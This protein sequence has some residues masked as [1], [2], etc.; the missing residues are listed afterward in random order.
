MKTSCINHPSQE[1]LIIK[2]RWQIQACDGDGCA[3]GLLS[4]FEYWHNI[5]L[6]NQVKAQQINHIAEMHGDDPT[7]DISLFQWHTAEELKASLF[8]YNEKRIRVSLKI[9]EV[10]GFISVHRN[11]NPKYAFDKTKYFLFHPAKVNEWLAERQ[12]NS[13]IQPRKKAIQPD[14]SCQIGDIVE[15]NRTD[16]SAEIASPI[17]RID[18]SVRSDLPKQYHKNTSKISSEI[19]SKG[20]NERYTVAQAQPVS[21]DAADPITFV[22]SHWKAT[23]CHTEAILDEKRKQVIRR[24]LKSG[25]LVEDLCQAISGC[26]NTPYNMG[27][28]DCGQRFDG[29]EW[30]LRNAD[31]IERFIRNYRTPPRHPKKNEDLFEKN[32]LATQLWLTQESITKEDLKNAV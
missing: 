1:P 24:A 11:P 26:A 16:H 12:N 25:Y 3:A 7:Q 10:K 29:L 18:R 30:I 2:H 14:P 28:N 27:D 23:M 5:K 31:Q 17:G 9:L 21:V 4:L 22:F 32:C 20:T 8:E 19:S 15:L 6:R 13:E